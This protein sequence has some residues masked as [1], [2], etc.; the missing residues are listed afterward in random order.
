M[1]N[2]FLKEYHHYLT[3]DEQTQ[4]QLGVPYWLAPEILMDEAYTEKVDVYSFGLLVWEL[5]TREFPFQSV[6]TLSKLIERVCVKG[7]R[8]LVPGKT[9]N[10][11][12]Y[13]I[14]F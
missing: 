8:P 7:E 10:N 5:L 2:R 11:F 3:S 12:F 14:F 4:K 6:E 9:L 13:L 1:G